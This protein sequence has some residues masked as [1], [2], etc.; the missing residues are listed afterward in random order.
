MGSGD[1]VRV[2]TDDLRGKA[3][4]IE[5]LTWPNQGGQ[6]QLMPPDTL[7]EANTAILNLDN[8]AR[9][10]G[11]IRSTADWRACGWRRR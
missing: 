2:D 11:T 9:G 1:E 4:Q 6:P 3:G 10:S 7:Q 8:N 5:G